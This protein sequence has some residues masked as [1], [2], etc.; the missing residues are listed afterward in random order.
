[1]KRLNT[2]AAGTD[3]VALD[4]FGAEL[5]GKK[6]QDIATVAAADAIGLGTMNYHKLALEEIAVS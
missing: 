2:I 5:L 6:P 1:M 4:A 3:I